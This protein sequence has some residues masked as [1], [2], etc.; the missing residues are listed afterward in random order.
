[1][2]PDTGQVG[3]LTQG[4]QDVLE[5]RYGRRLRPGDR[6]DEERIVVSPKVAK[7]MRLG[8]KVERKREKSRGRRKRAEARAR[9]KG[10]GS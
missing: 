8:Q 10:V 7:R 5:G 2:N 9:A 4:D 6:I 1:M 3:K